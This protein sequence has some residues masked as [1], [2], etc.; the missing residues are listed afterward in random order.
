MRKSFLYISLA[1]TGATLLSLLYYRGGNSCEGHFSF[2]CI[3]YSYRGY[4][5]PLVKTE[6]I[7]WTDIFGIMQFFLNVLIYFLLFFAIY[8]IYSKLFKKSKKK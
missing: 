1:S 7:Y 2:E 8:F 4:P 3:D 5:F 6:S